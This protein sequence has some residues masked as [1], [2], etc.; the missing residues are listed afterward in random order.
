MAVWSQNWCRSVNTQQHL[1][2]NSFDDSRLFTVFCDFD[3]TSLVHRHHHHHH[4]A[5]VSA[6]LCE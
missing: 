4:V 2:E 1:I 6:G 3:M 5:N